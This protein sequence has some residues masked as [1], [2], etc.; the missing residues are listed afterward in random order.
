MQIFHCTHC[1]HLV[2]F[3][4]VQ[5]LF[6]QRSLAYLPDANTML[7]LEAPGSSDSATPGNIR[8][9]RNYLERGV[10]NWAIAADDPNEFCVS[11]RTTH[12]IPALDDQANLQR[13][14]R[15]EGAKRRLIVN[16]LGLGL[17]IGDSS[18]GAGDGLRF[19]FLA[20]SFDTPVMTGH[21]HGT[22]TLNVDETDDVERERRR[23]MLREPYRTVLG[24]LRH[25]TGHYYWDRLIWN[26]SKLDQFRD[27]FGDE[28]ADYE[29]ALQNYYA[30][31]PWGNWQN[32][33]VSAYASAHPW[34]DWAESWAHYLHIMDTLETAAACGL[35]LRPRR[36]DEPAVA[37]TDLN[38]GVMRGPFEA[39]IAAWYPVTYLLNSLNRGLGL[40]DPYP[41]VLTDAVVGK[42][43]FIHDTVVAS[44]ADLTFEQGQSIP[45]AA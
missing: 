22:I 45:Q 6:C 37:L 33:F 16:L 38:R 39:A 36:S 26:G 9:C 15:A 40:P 4:S 32:S 31:G 34:E 30:N 11:C 28:R 19:E 42:L 1:Q 43:R 27:L 13:W 35:T 14:F 20:P 44:R 29:G 12:V 23:N 5:C 24:H 18:S 2:F 25:E 3:E 8:L 17:P 7:A 41:F 10:C 21:L